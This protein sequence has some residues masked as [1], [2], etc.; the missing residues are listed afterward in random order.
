MRKKDEGGC[1]LFIL[2]SFHLIHIREVPWGDYSDATSI[3]MGCYFLRFIFT[4]FGGN[5]LLLIIKTKSKVFHYF[6]LI[7]KYSGDQFAPQSKLSDAGCK[8]T[9]HCMVDGVIQYHCVAKLCQI[10]PLGWCIHIFL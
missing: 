7:F 9:E 2:P 1:I 6:F 8:F 5:F 10:A 4:L 3:E